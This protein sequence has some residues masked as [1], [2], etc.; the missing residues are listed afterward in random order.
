MTHVRD[1][2]RGDMRNRLVQRIDKPLGFQGREVMRL[3]RPLKC[4][5]KSIAD[6]GADGIL[7]VKAQ[8]PHPEVFDQKLTSSGKSMTSC[9]K[10]N[11]SG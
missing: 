9:S 3:I 6:I 1:S 4:E 7:P 5:G 10:V 11:R 8:E 2:V